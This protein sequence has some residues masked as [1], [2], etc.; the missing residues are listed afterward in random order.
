MILKPKMSVEELDNKQ[1]DSDKISK[2]PNEDNAYRITEK[3]TFPRLVGSEGEKK[4]I[5]IITNEFKSAGYDSIYKDNFETSFYV[6]IVLRYGFFP[7]GICLVLLGLTFFI[8]PINSLIKG[9]SITTH[10]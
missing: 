6:W 7:I 2:K 1:E 5:E 3:L 8:N 10:V 9:C 4:A